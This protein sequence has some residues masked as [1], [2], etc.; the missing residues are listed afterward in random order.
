MRRGRGVKVQA[1]RVGAYKNRNRL[2]RSR[3]MKK[4]LAAPLRRLP[5]SFSPANPSAAYI[6][7]QCPI[8]FLELRMAPRAYWK[9]HLRLSL[10]SCPIELYPA[11]SEREKISFNQ[12]NSKTGNRIKYKK[13]DAATGEEVDSH[14]II[15]GLPIRE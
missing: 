12:L 10:V 9:G 6:R 4:I 15:K 7:G 2:P 13:V 11:T 5:L 14:D 8:A 1:L 3:H